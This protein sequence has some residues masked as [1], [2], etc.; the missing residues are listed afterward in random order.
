MTNH[1]ELFNTFLEA[2]KAMEEL[3]QVK[4]EL[5]EVKDQLELIART[6]TKTQFAILWSETRLLQALKSLATR[7]AELASA[8]FREAEASAKINNLRA[9]L[10]TSEPVPVVATEPVTGHAWRG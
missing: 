8:T 1:A 5:T 10:G 3:P 9:I 6:A 7:E 4:A 2:G